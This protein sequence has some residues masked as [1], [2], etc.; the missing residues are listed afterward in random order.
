MYTK[1]APA[2]CGAILRSSPSSNVMV[3][4]RNK[5]PK[6]KMIVP[7]VEFVDKVLD[8][9]SSIQEDLYQRALKF[10]EENTVTVSSMDEFKS[11]FESD[12]SGFA[13]CYA[14]D[15]ADIQEKLDPYKVTPRC[16]LPEHEQGRCIFTGEEGG[17]K[18]VFSRSY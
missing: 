17:V 14:K 9:L 10:R 7:R 12:K 11:Y 2:Y 16:I 5:D 3:S 8:L 15:C 13:V 18:T 1:I 6:D 4:L